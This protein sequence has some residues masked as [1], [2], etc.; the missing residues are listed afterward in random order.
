[1]TLA[2]VATARVALVRHGRSSHAHSGWIDAAGF[3]AWRVAYEGAGIVADE[4]VPAELARLVADEVCVAS[5]DAP[6][7]LASAR[8]LSPAGEVRISP[9]LREL[10]LEGPALGRVRLPLFGWALAVGLR[11]LALRLRGRYPSPPER[12][13]L[14][15]AADWIE[16]LSAA[17]PRLVV[18]THASFRR[19]LAMR[20]VAN[21][22]RAQP[23][24]RSVDHWSAWLFE[25]TAVPPVA[26]YPTTS[27]TTGS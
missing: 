1:M 24:R 10:D 23:G 4:Q 13:R 9:L 26:A 25:R 2:P 17:H 18:L 14:R 5:S 27:H 12:A 21:G 7:A 8:L 19:R 3:R 15:E 11:M 16:R 6:R 22:W 20:L